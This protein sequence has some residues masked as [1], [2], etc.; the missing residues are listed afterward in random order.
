MTDQNRPQPALPSGDELAAALDQA[1]K[2]GE[3]VELSP[4]LL[5]L[6]VGWLK[7]NRQV[8]MGP[9]FER[10]KSVQCQVSWNDQRADEAA[11]SRT[12]QAVKAAMLPEAK[13]EPVEESQ[14]TGQDWNA[15]PK[16]RIAVLKTLAHLGNERGPWMVN[17][18]LQAMQPASQQTY[19]RN[20]V[21]GALK[22]LVRCGHVARPEGPKSGSSATTLGLQWLRKLNT[23]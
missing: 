10:W 6:A 21:L 22:D 20:I 18:I 8:Q 2:R 15:K 16:Q 1:T 11:A 12:L 23:Q 13:P 9:D 5:E 14:P 17:E 3:D 19:G 4:E 7:D